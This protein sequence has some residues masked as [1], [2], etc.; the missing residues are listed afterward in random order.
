MLHSTPTQDKTIESSD[1]QPIRTLFKDYETTFVILHPFLI[2]KPDCNIKF[3]MPYPNKRQIIDCALKIA[4]QQIL[5]QTGLENIKQLDQLLAYLHCARRTADKTNW[6]KLMKVI[7]TNNYGVPQ[8]D[9]F[10]E[11]ITNDLFTSIKLLGYYQVN[12]ISEMTGVDKVIDIDE[13][14]SSDEELPLVSTITTPDKKILVA[15]EFDQAFSYLSSTKEVVK[16]L[17]NDADLEGFF[18]NDTT[19]QGWSYVEQKKNIIDWSSKERK[20]NYA[21][22]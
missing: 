5:E 6:E 8:V 12:I 3:E 7:H 1:E 15:T 20:K 13:I 16:K 18:C 10:P 17:I 11:I 21:Q 2:A 14:L 9:N 19:R 22:K 4:W